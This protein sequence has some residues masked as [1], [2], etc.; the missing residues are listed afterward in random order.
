MEMLRNYKRTI[1]SWVSNSS[2]HTPQISGTV[3]LGTP[4][5]I[6]MVTALKE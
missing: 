2:P 5:T 1:N 4:Q 6:C 3:T